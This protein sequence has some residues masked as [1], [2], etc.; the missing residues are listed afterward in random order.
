MNKDKLEE[1]KQAL[2]T[3]KEV[4]MAKQTLEEGKINV[5]EELERLRKVNQELEA[6]VSEL[7]ENLKSSQEKA[8]ENNDKYVRLYAEFDNFRKRLNREKEEHARYAHEQ[9]VKDLLPVMDDLD[10]ALTHAQSSS[11]V[12]ALIQGVEMVKKHMSSA[13]EKYGL[14]S[15]DSLGQPFDPHVHEAVAHQE[16]ADYP[17]DVVINEYRKGYTLHDKLVRP[18]MVA[19]SKG[20]EK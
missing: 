5:L 1:L 19:V 20:N 17:P 9:V 15:F 13:L 18:A 11:E 14:K 6:K 8:N 16:S 4:E 10:R 7:E 3:K 2:K 12:P